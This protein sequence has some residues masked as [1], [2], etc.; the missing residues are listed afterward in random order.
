LISACF[1]EE[2]EGTTTAAFFS[3]LERVVMVFVGDEGG[4]RT[5]NTRFSDTGW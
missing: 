1:A 2:T 4:W 5:Q 3:F